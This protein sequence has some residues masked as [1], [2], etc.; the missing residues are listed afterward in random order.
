MAKLVPI[1]DRVAAVRIK[2]EL[3]TESGIVLENTRSNEVDKAKVIAIGPEVDL[4]E[5][6][7]TILI[8]W[9][10]VQVATIEGAPVYIL[11][12]DDIH[13]VIEQ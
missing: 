13:G 12:Q 8:D 5:I 9:S 11:S 10:K 7:Q 1:K 2:S 3:K 4:V 6:G